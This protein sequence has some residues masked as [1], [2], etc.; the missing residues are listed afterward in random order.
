[1][2]TIDAYLL[3][4]VSGAV[5]VTALVVVLRRFLARTGIVAGARHMLGVLLDQQQYMHREFAHEPGA[6]KMLHTAD[7]MVLGAKAALDELEKEAKR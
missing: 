5:V 1:M 4:V 6:E 2:N 7:A 3:G